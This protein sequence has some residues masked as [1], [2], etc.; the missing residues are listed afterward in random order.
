MFRSRVDRHQF[1]AVFKKKEKRATYKT[2]SSLSSVGSQKLP[3][4]YSEAVKLRGSVSS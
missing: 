1:Y 2:D 3:Y 4:F